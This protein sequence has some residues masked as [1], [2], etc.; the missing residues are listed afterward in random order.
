MHIVW[1]TLYF[2]SELPSPPSTTTET[3]Y[4]IN[5]YTDYGEFIEQKFEYQ[6]GRNTKGTTFVINGRTPP[7]YDISINGGNN[8]GS[9]RGSL[10]FFNI[11]WKISVEF[12]ISFNL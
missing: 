9:S 1:I 8:G 7:S 5:A 4:Y 11:M 3:E 2:I 10:I 6:D 12:S